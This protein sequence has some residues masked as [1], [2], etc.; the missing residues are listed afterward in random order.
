MSEWESAGL[1]HEKIA[2]TYVGCAEC[3]DYWPLVD[4]FEWDES[5]C[6]ECGGDLHPRWIDG[7]DVKTFVE[8]GTTMPETPT[9]C[10]VCGKDMG[11][12]TMKEVSLCRE[13][14]DSGHTFDEIDQ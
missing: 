9:T 10:G 1:N 8:H 12:D 7:E 4:S 11:E 13:C 3:R 6:P 14:W 5:I 2:S